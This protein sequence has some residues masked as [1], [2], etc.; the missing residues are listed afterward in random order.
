[1]Q[2]DAVYA[3]L[4]LIADNMISGVVTKMLPSLKGKTALGEL[5]LIIVGDELFEVEKLVAN[6]NAP[7][8]IIG[9]MILGMREGTQEEYIAAGWGPSD[10]LITGVINHLL[11]EDDADDAEDADDDDTAGDEDA[12]DEESEDG[13]E[14]KTGVAVA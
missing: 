1:M 2:Y 10:D 6:L 9:L 7:S 13:L 12:D 8:Q 3:V 14:V 5:E 11:N 4:P